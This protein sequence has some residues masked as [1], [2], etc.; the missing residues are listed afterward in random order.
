MAGRGTDIVL[1]GNAEYLAKSFAERVAKASEQ[2]GEA[3]N[4]ADAYKEFLEQFRK[5]VAEEHE[6]VVGVGGL[7]VLGTER[8]ESRRIDNQ[9]RGRSGRQGDPGSS[10]F[11]VSLEDDLMRLFGSDRMMNLMN[12]LGM[13]EGQVIEHPWVS[14]AIEIAQKRVETHNFEI[15]KQLL[16]YD[17]VMNRQRE[18]IYAMRRSILNGED[19][20]ERIVLAL[21]DHLKTLVKQYLFS[22]NVDA[23]MD[24]KGF[25]LA[26]KT[27]FHL[28]A[29]AVQ[30]RFEQMSQEQ[31]EDMV[32]EKI[33]EIY[34][35][36]ET[37]ITTDQMRALERMIL[38]Q[39]ID[40][41]WKDH[42]YAM[43]QLKEG[44]GLRSYAHRDPLVEYQR[45]AFAMFEAMYDS[46]MAEA[47]EMVFKVE[48]VRDQQ[49]PKG[50]FSSLPQSFV[51]AEHSSLSSDQSSSVPGGLPAE[52]RSPSRQ[53]QARSQDKVGRNDP[54]PC[55]SGKKHKKCCGQ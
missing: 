20:K 53:P 30:G 52:S 4:A 34:T 54:C 36:K 39:T 31:I 32:Y 38:L 8:H 29:S 13:E 33:L 16:E 49:R 1:G 25:N 48:P 42:L 55:G 14:G 9:L 11:F 28:D 15:R 2:K 3:K 10:R 45:E 6:K 18:V 47:V 12:T 7:H 24:L 21:E 37:L 50:V 44:I 51:H 41:K 5:Q 23:G 22:G 40:L 19:I 26:L 43:D 27:I 17:N 35:Q 46:I